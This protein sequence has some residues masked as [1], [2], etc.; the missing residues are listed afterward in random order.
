MDNPA[1]EKDIIINA[2]RSKHNLCI[3]GAAGTG[4]SHLLK[5][6]KEHFPAIH[7]TAS[8][9]IAAVNVS[10]VTIHSWAG[11]GNGTLPLEEILKHINS[12]PGTK[13]RRQIKKAKILAIDEVSMISN[14]TMDLINSVFKFV[15]NSEKAFGGMQI[16]LFGDFYQL[17][18]IIKEQDEDFCF[19]SDSW[20]DAEFKIYE[21]TKIYRQYDMKFIQ[22]LNNIRHAALSDEDI[23]LLKTFENK[24]VPKDINPT[25]LV[26][27]NYQAEEINRQKITELL[28]QEEAIFNMKT[29]GKDA[30]INFLKK[31]CLAQESIILRKGCQVM[32]LKNTYQKQGIINGS[33]GIVTGFIGKERFPIVQFANGT[34]IPI[35]P[36]E[37]N[38]EIFNEEK[39][40][41]ETIATIKQIPLTL[42]WAITIHKSQGMTLDCILCDL[43]KIFAE[44]QAYVAISRL[45]NLDGLY[46][47]GF[48]PRNLKINPKVRE[49]YNRTEKNSIFA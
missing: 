23:E 5:I 35:T 24:P 2:I 12:G 27:H 31:N 9:G 38:V 37:W 36:E 43:S 41:K 21:L 1:Q 49:F 19:N 48:N 30:S 16:I 28:G 39:Q 8:T 17:P 6:V 32:M 3:T 44:G 42:A 34:K 13:V 20:Q 45:K 46:L 14:K 4:K 11:I 10:G 22:L 7:I 40:I 47:K 15:R 25:I 26:T 33:I 18:P 29:T